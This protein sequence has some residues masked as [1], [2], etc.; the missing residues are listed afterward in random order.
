MRTVPRKLPR[1]GARARAA[2]FRIGQLGPEQRRVIER[3]LRP[4]AIEDLSAV[5][6]A[7]LE[8]LLGAF[9]DVLTDSAGPAAISPAEIGRIL[10]RPHRLDVDLR[11]TR[12]VAAAAFDLRHE[13]L[14]ASG[15][16]LR[17]DRA[18]RRA[19]APRGGERRALHWLPW[20]H[21]LAT[22]VAGAKARAAGFRLEQLDPPQLRAVERALA[23]D[24]VADLAPLDR[25]ELESILGAFVDVL[26]AGA[27]PGAIEA[28][29]LTRIIKRP[30]RLRVRRGHTAALA[31]AV[32]EQRHEELVASGVL[33]PALAP[34]TMGG[35]QAGALDLE[36]LPRRHLAALGRH[37]LRRGVRRLSSRDRSHLEARLE[38][39]LAHAEP[40]RPASAVAPRRLVTLLEAPSDGS[41]YAEL[42]FRAQTL[43]PSWP[44]RGSIDWTRVPGTRT[45]RLEGKLRRAGKATALRVL[46][47]QAVSRHWLV[48]VAR[49]E[50]KLPEVVALAVSLLLFVVLERGLIAPDASERWYR[51]GEPLLWQWLD[52][53]SPVRVLLA[54]T[55][56][57]LLAWRVPWT[58]IEAGPW[59]RRLATGAALLL[60]LSAWATP[61]NP[62]FGR[63]FVF[64]RAVVLG[65]G[66]LTWISPA[67]LVPLL[68]DWSLFEQ[69]S[70]FPYSGF[71]LLP[72]LPVV[73]FLLAVL[74]VAGWRVLARMDGRVVIA[75]AAMPVVA[76][77]FFSGLRVLRLGPHAWT[78][79]VEERPGNLL[80]SAWQH[81]WLAGLDESMILAARR[82]LN[83][84]APALLVP[85]TVLLVLSPFAF[86]RRRLATVVFA[87]LLAAEV[88][89]FLL[90][91]FLWWG[92]W[93]V[94]AML[95]G[96]ALT[97]H[98]ELTPLFRS[99][100]AAVVLA[101]TAIAPW[102]L[103]PRVLAWWSTPY[104]NRVV[105][106]AVD[107]RGRVGPTTGWYG[108]YSAP[109]LLQRLYGI[110]ADARLV[111]THGMTSHY[112]LYRLLSRLSAREG[113]E[114]DRLASYMSP[115][116]PDTVA[117]ARRRFDRLVRKAAAEAATQPGWA[118][119]LGGLRWL[120]P[121]GSNDAPPI[122]GVRELR[123]RVEESLMDDDRL[124][125]YRSRVVHRV[126]VA[127]APAS[128]SAALGRP[129]HPA[130]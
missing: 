48:G 29:T 113:A 76:S 112:G 126:E 125:V 75:L 85:L 110:Q 44:A 19:A 90:T 16:A 64:E 88:V 86:G 89:L 121:L 95:L 92:W 127:P 22:P 34:E 12:A 129:R 128:R 33:A 53:A 23:P 58:R 99:R 35:P 1:P 63:A 52:A 77:F 3:S 72:A 91:G 10:A 17:S 73:W 109:F 59:L 32:F 84:G 96:A 41:D 87:G 42:R 36:A 79:A 67:A 54:V 122:H 5:E 65:C 107:E 31:K 123:V 61:P 37:F 97:R 20:R 100:L 14:V 83:A 24:R 40:G 70:R 120:H 69:Q 46:A 49:G 51:S 62:Y 103:Q 57:F 124:V 15:A 26:T 116:G 55:L 11:K 130:S 98:A 108:P 105:V 39:F 104:N 118:R 25:A 81:G 38:V 4:D 74:A 68:I 50:I 60:A 27:G 80:A 8:T 56:T 102:L 106:E 43:A 114:V 111:D 47:A 6:R 28:R 117:M 78:W 45:A 30:S 13:E 21:P 94:T 2:A 9:V 66:L 71:E 93:A 115:P 119:R 7:R 82:L 18:G 101:G